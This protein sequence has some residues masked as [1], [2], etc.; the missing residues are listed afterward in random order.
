M[1]GTKAGGYKARETNKRKYGND[2]YYEPYLEEAKV[3]R[4]EEE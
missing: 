3:L 1:A 4:E 2:W